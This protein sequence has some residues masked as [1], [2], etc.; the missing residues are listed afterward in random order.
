MPDSTRHDQAEAAIEAMGG[1]DA[2]L[3]GTPSPLDGL[4]STPT[5]AGT[6]Q[7]IPTALPTEAAPRT[8]PKWNELERNE[9][10][11]WVR[12]HP[13]AQATPES[14]ESQTESPQQAPTDT[15]FIDENFDPSSLPPELQPGYKQMQGHFT[16]RMQEIKAQEEQY[17][18]FGDPQEIAQAVEL[19]NVLRDPSNYKQLH[20]ELSEYLGA[21]TGA[22]P[23]EASQEAHRQLENAT[24]PQ[25]GLA[26]SLAQLDD[27]FE[28]VKTEFARLQ[29]ELASMKTEFNTYKEQRE[30]QELEL[31][32]VGEIQRQVGTLRQQRPDYTDQDIDGI[33]ELS[34]FYNGDIQ[35]AQKRY[36]DIFTDRM[37]RYLASK[38][39]PAEPSGIFAGGSVTT[40]QPQ[41]TRTWAEAKAAALAVADQLDNGQ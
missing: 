3:Q 16:R 31:A 19:R 7:E 41:G 28:P 36:D 21:S 32:L 6:T 5:E 12:G 24:Q 14:V 34:T 8:V 33:F 9:L 22:T 23:Q 11:Q 30:A 35:Q 37:S 25:P 27:E 4:T 38:Q 2:A 10:G 39:S 26:P 1:L 13:T 29:G 20:Q 15:S 17:A 18:Q 40:A